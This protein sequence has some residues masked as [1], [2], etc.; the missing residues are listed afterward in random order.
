MRRLF[1]WAP[2]AADD[3]GDLFSMMEER[4]GK[5]A[6]RGM[7]TCVRGRE[8]LAD[9]ETGLPQKEAEVEVEDESAKL[10]RELAEARAAKEEALGRTTGSS[11][12]S[13]RRRKQRGLLSPVQPER[14]PS[15]ESTTA[16]RKQVQQHTPQTQQASKKKRASSLFATSPA[17]L[18]G[19]DAESVPRHLGDNLWIRDTVTGSGTEICRSGDTVSVLYSGRLD[20]TNKRFDH[21]SNPLKPFNFVL[22][23]KTVVDGF[24]RGLEGMRVGGERELVVPPQLAY[25]QRGAPPRIPENATLHFTVKLVAMPN[26]GVVDFGSANEDNDDKKKLGGR[27]R[28]RGT[29]GGVRV[30]RHRRKLQ[31]AS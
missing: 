1:G 15:G 30:N 11:R 6:A 25:G 29:R 19:A 16:K 4:W 13:L 27:R 21:V 2:M 20:A 7:R 10:L 8:T 18:L 24:D 12:A 28:P 3:E 23:D 9:G 17:S 26:G 5:R 14:P 22:G 31:E